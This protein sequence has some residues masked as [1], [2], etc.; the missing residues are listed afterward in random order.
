MVGLGLKP[1]KQLHIRIQ[2][3]YQP[4]VAMTTENP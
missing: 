2:G 3:A 4:F 1:T